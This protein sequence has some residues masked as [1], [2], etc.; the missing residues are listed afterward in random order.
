[1]G[2]GMA[3]NVRKSMP[4]E[5]VLY[6]FDVNTSVCQKFKQDFGSY[7]DIEIVQ[8]AKNTAENSVAVVSMLP[9]AAIVRETFLDSSKGVIAARKNSDRVL[10]ECSTIDSTSAQDIGEKTMAAGSGVYIDAPVSVGLTFTISATQHTADT[11]ISL[12]RGANQVL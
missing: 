1:M 10:L 9:S 3:S 12:N 6:I 11:C 4:H 2:Y 7:G 5:C 8:E